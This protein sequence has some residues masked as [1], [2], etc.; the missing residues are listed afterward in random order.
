VKLREIEV[1]G[2]YNI[3]NY[4]NVR[5]AVRFEVESEAGI[6]KAVEVLSKLS[7]IAHALRRIY[8]RIYE[9]D[10][11]V[12]ELQH[13]LDDAE[14]RKNKCVEELKAQLNSILEKYR[15]M[16]KPEVVD[17]I[18]K[19][20]EQGEYGKCVEILKPLL[21][22]ERLP[23]CTRYVEEIERIQQ[24]LAEIQTRKNELAELKKK[25]HEL[26][27]KGSIDEAV[28]ICNKFLSTLSIHSY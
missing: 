28:E 6:A 26:A 11:K 5:I 10:R 13:E 16:L 18:A 22:C 8:D 21:T 3:G 24:R 17:E 12:E 2:T 1:G 9:L 20:A 23:E 14:A 15:E 27:E 4:E 19:L 7:V 25:I